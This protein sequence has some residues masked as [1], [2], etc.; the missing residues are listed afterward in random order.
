MIFGTTMVRRQLSFHS[1]SFYSGGS[2]MLIPNNDDRSQ[3]IQLF[4]QESFQTSLPSMIALVI[5]A[6]FWLP[7]EI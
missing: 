5:H 2:I 3:I 7:F 6:I 4:R 1:F